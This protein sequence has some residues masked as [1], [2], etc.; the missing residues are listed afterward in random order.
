MAEK[1]TLLEIYAPKSLKDLYLPK[2]IHTLLEETT[3][4]KSG[5]KVFQAGSPG[6]GKTSVGRELSR[7]GD[8]LYL[9]GSN[10]FN[11]DVMRSKVYPF[12]SGH[13]VL[14]KQKFLVIDE[15]ENIPNKLQD[16]FK[17][18]LD[19]AKSV[20]FVFNTNEPEMVN[21]AIKS[22]CINIAYDYQREEVKEQQVHYIT[23][24]TRIC[25]ENGIKWDNR[26]IKLLFQMNFPDFRHLL[27]MLQQFIDSK[28]DV[29]E[30]NVT[31]LSENG[32]ANVELYK[33]IEEE[34]NPQAFYEKATSWKGKE[35][36][37]LISLGEP[38]FTWLN[39]RGKFEQTLAAASIVADYSFKFVT[40]I[41]KFGTFFAC[42]CELKTVFR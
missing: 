40:T 38:Y 17:I 26:G 10:D 21:T 25:N 24:A 31:I 4:G 30:D 3:V 35:R 9:S 19:T 1:K 7:G 34:H 12:V 8:V 13:S 29:I 27:V 18:V 5:W 41:N 22:R 20:N 36:E 42:L 33:L 16:G 39:K 32:T 37:C 11:V 28:R 2:R 15:C 23:Y 14:G 6:T